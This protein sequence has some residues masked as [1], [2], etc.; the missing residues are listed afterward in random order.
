MKSQEELVHKQYHLKGHPTF[1]YRKGKTYYYR[2]KIP[3]DLA[4]LYTK[5]LFVQSLRT[6]SKS[7]A[8]R[9]STALTAKLE[10]QWLAMRLTI[11]EAPASH[12]LAPKGAHKSDVMDLNEALDCYLSV[13]GRGRP[14]TFTT[15][16]Q[17]QVKYAVECLGCRS[18]DRYSSADAAKFRDWLLA[19]N[20]S[21][22]SISRIF[23]GI[24]AIFSLCIN[25]YGLGLSNPF[26]GVYLGQAEQSIKRK[27][28]SL[29][30]IKLIGDAC[31][32]QRDELRNLLGLIIDTGMRLGEA[33]GLKLQDINLTGPVPYVVIKS[34]KARGLKTKNSE[35]VLPLVGYSLSTAQWIV[36]HQAGDYCFPRYAQDG[37][38]NANSASAALNK[39]IKSVGSKEIV[40]HGFRHSFRDRLRNVQAPIDL[41]DQLGGW[42]KE[43]IGVGYGDGYT[44]GVANSF[45]MKIVVC[46]DEPW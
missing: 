35:R 33:T 45:A 5:P 46:C 20:L 4:D 18:L 11:N 28:V 37:Y 42:S 9:L 21:Q 24:K 2:R 38:C 23:S 1:T 10:E 26:S 17:R 31:L 14:L 3:Q 39:W 41:I 44:L 30:D 40:V 25:E 6:N 43:S 32:K 7:V 15:H 12:L 36:E 16:A 8:Q 13:K 27:P 22:S 19:R 29:D 34:N